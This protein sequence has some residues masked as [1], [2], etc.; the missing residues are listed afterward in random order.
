[1]TNGATKARR[2]WIVLVGALALTALIVALRMRASAQSRRGENTREG[3]TQD[4]PI[5]VLVAQAE[6]RDVPIYL[7]GLGTVAAYATVTVRPRVEGRLDAVL[8]REG[9]SVRRGDVLAQIDPR[10]FQIQLQQAQALVAR[11]R[12]Q[13]GV[14]RTTFE[15]ARSLVEQNLIARQEFDTARGTFEQLQAAV[16]ADEAQVANA[17]LSLDY[18]R[19]T[20]PIDG[21]TGL[22]LID[23]G[24]VVRT[25]DGIV[26]VTQIDPIAVMF[27]LPQDELPRVAERMAQGALPV[28]VYSRD[29]DTRIATGELAVIDNQIN[30]ATAT[31]RLKAVFPNPERRLWPSQFVKT[32]LLVNTRRGALVIPAAAVQH[33]PQGVFVYVVGAD[34]RVA[35]R[36]VRVERTE[37]ESAILTEGIN[38]GE[39]VVTE[40]QNRLRPGARA[41]VRTAGEQ[42][43]RSENGTRRG[44]RSR[45][46][47]APR[48]REAA[49]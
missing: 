37:G 45:D 13:A 49:P 2:W 20:S 26:V 25:T 34:G 12:A 22:R 6:R 1:M 29:G 9:Q 7:E 46:G 40:G 38:P 15:R 47:G 43:E 21:V 18:A 39:Q 23:A 5:P 11:D 41:Q 30:V 4:R 42:G 31:A 44:G 3:A 14:G 19:V 16:R 8:F 10:P 35:S 48:S 28:E 17:R 36:P 27:Q 24:N 32:R 33:G